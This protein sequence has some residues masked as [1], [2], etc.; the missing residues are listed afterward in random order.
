MII[1]VFSHDGLCCK[2]DKFSAATEGSEI[3]RLIDGVWRNSLSGSNLLKPKIREEN[4][5]N[6]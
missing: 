2:E 3:K 4:G 1:I 6:S 5:G